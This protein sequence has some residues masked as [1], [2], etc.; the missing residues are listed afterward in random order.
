MQLMKMYLAG[1]TVVGET[2]TFKSKKVLMQ[3]KKHRSTKMAH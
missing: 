2:N 1:D 3:W